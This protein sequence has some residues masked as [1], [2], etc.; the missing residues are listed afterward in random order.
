[1]TNHSFIAEATTEVRWYT[2]T[3][4]HLSCVTVAQTHKCTFEFSK[5]FGSQLQ[6]HFS[7]DLADKNKSRRGWKRKC[8]AHVCRG[9]DS[10]PFKHAAG[11]V[12][13]VSLL[14]LLGDLASRVA[15]LS[16]NSPNGAQ[17]RQ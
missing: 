4:C 3:C 10:N 14:L 7:G 8:Q 13:S 2:T 17:R 15:A 9:A 1:M 11:G 16:K 6:E 12:L 5:L